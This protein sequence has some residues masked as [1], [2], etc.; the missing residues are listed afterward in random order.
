[1]SVASAYEAGGEGDEP[2]GVTEDDLEHCGIGF[3][4]CDR[5]LDGGRR[6]ARLA[7]W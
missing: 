6:L 5:D 2:I 3:P 4:R 7:R 1:V